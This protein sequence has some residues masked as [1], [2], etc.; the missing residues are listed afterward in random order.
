[1]DKNRAALLAGLLVLL[2]AGLGI[3][4]LVTRD[5]TKAPRV[6]NET[7]EVAATQG[8]RKSS[9]RDSREDGPESRGSGQTTPEGAQKGT[10]EIEV[11]PEVPTSITVSGQAIDFSE[12]AA[13]G[14]TLTLLREDSEDASGATTITDDSGEFKFEVELVIGKGYFVACV[15]EGMA[16][17]A[18]GTFT[19]KENTNIEGL[20]IQVFAEA[21]AHG[22]VLNGADNTPLADV[23]IELD[24]RTDARLQRLGRILGRVKPVKSDAQGKYEVLHIAP[25]A[26]LVYARKKGWMSNELN[27][28]TRSR[29]EIELAEF[30][31]LELLPFVLVQAGAIEGRVLKR[32]DR[33]PVAGARVELGTVLGGMLDSTT[34]DSEGKY[35]FDQVPPGIGAPGGEGDGMGGAAVRA[36]AGGYAIA[37][38][39]LRVRS[40]ETRTGI[41]LLL[42]D[43]ASVTG[44]VVDTKQQPIAGA[45]VYYND[46]DFLRGGEWVAGLELPKRTVQTTTDAQGRFTLAN[47]PVGNVGISARAKGYANKTAQAVTTAGQSTEITIVLEPAGWIEGVVSN[48][49]GEPVEG[50]PLA[51]YDVSGP[52]QLSFVMKSFF[53]ET[54]PDRGESTMF[55]AGVRSDAEGR[56]RLDGL[57]AGKYVLLANTRSY[58]KYVSPELE[59]KNGAGTTHDV[60]L[61]S[62]GTIYG[63]VYDAG[64]RAV[65]GVPVT[66]AS[67]QGQDSANVRTAY[68]DSGGN[69]ELT[70]LVPG[71]YTVIRNTGNFA[72]LILPNPSNQVKVAADQRVEFDI[73]EQ[74]PGTAR[75]HGRVTEDGKPYADKTIVLIGGGRGGFAAST[76]RTDK[77]GY[78]EFNSVALGVYQ[79]AQ[80]GQ[81][82]A[83]SLVRKRVSVNREGDFEFDVNFETVKIIGRVEVEGGKV[84]QGRVRVI[85]SPVSADGTDK[86]NPDEEV[87]ELEMMVA[88]ETGID[89]KTGAFELTGMSPGFYRLSVRSENNGMVTRPYLNVRAT[90]SGVV[91]TLP[92]QG[93]TL[94]GTL[95]GIDGAQ[96]NTPFGL[97][98]ALTIED[99]RGSPIALGG[100]DNGVNLT[101]SKAFE[102]KNLPEGRFTITLSMPGYTPVTH[103]NVQ[104]KAGETVSLTFAFASAGHLKITMLN[105]D[106][107]IATALGLEY[108]IR[109][110]KG[111]LFKKR[112]TFLDFFN[113]DG[114][115][116]QGENNSFTI[117]DLPPE[118]YTISM[119]MPGYKPLSR[120]FTIIAGE[121]SE[122]SVEFQKE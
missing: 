9:Q 84:P 97:I 49:R 40:G 103:S 39:D 87:S 105:N 111:E 50:V 101:Q 77:D 17:T 27:P 82:P 4:W 25:G 1:M 34:T 7:D 21:R 112:F 113:S 10:P 107:D 98:A 57:P 104:F 20:L 96:N 32:S 35:R 115:T 83:P 5:S 29:Q 78:Y 16:L 74:K 56:Y 48:S 11:V 63:R 69:Y 71:T 92:A 65:P 75:L 14:I 93:A 46:N 2:L 52:G 100:F 81:G 30:G 94:K 6:T 76:A 95:T 67:L 22:V 13:P 55:P 18:T 38:R 44:R 61:S 47:I 12:E 119:T 114:S 43:G 91:L 80:Q 31:N 89:E 59:V 15:Q 33:S 58:Q 3:G 85:A 72:A 8:K 73:H 110:S 70:G 86:G 121:T 62:G 36:I 60:S 28:L 102:I 79:I 88:R 109:N 53:G 90:V 19:V 45:S 120:A 108:E 66:C 99:E 23:D 41:D 116:T 24:A 64:G 118:S 37:T 51:A 68:T 122:I 54:L 26:Y 117:K 42:D 106:I